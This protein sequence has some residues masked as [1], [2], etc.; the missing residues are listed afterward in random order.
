MINFDKYINFW[1]NQ[2]R[3]QVFIDNKIKI[4][5]NRK[6]IPHLYH[7]TSLGTFHD[8]ANNGEFWAHNTRFSNDYSEERIFPVEFRESISCDTDN[9]FICLINDGDSLSMWRG[10]C[11]DGGVSVEMVFPHP[12]KLSFSIVEQDNSGFVKMKSNVL[13]IGYLAKE[14]VLSLF[15]ALKKDNNIEYLPL[16]KYDWFKEEKEFRILLINEGNLDK[17]VFERKIEKGT[18]VPYIKV[19]FDDCSQ[20]SNTI[21]DTLSSLSFADLK[22]NEI[23]SKVIYYYGTHYL[24]VP[25]G[26]QQKSAYY[27]LSKI[28]KEGTKITKNRRDNITLLCEGYPPITK[29]TVAPMIDQERVVEQ[30]EHFCKS[31][32]WLSNVPVVASQIPYVTTLG[33]K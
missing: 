23:N 32:Y 5:A 9:Y 14:R 11:P 27:N 30:I 1:E 24:F 16:I 10:Y 28:I 15:S 6:I 13:P 12:D 7:Y 8:I 18:Y 4:N 29:I 20:A 2:I 31:R 19:K 25:A 17:C 33:K 26:K 3:T 22:N 21:T